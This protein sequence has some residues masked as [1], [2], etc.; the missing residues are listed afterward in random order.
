MYHHYIDENNLPGRLIYNA[1]EI[2][3]EVSCGLA[4][5]AEDKITIPKSLYMEVPHS[6]AIYARE[7]ILDATTITNVKS[8][9]IAAE[10][11][12]NKKLFMTSSDN[13]LMNGVGNQNVPMPKSYIHSSIFSVVEDNW[14]TNITAQAE[15]IEISGTLNAEHA[16]YNSRSFTLTES[17]IIQSVSITI[18]IAQDAHLNGALTTYEAIFSG[19]N[20]ILC[21]VFAINVLKVKSNGMTELCPDAQGSIGTI[22]VT[23]ASQFKQNS[24]VTI[25]NLLVIKADDVNLLTEALPEVIKAGSKFDN[26]NITAWQFAYSGNIYVANNGTLAL[27][28]IRD[29]FRVHDELL[30][31]HIGLS[32]KND[33]VNEGSI[34]ANT[35]TL[36]SEFGSFQTKQSSIIQVTE[37]VHLSIWGNIFNAGSIKAGAATF[38]SSSG[39]FKAEAQS[40]IHVLGHMKLKATNNVINYGFIKASTA[41]FYLRSQFKAGKNSRLYVDG[42]SEFRFSGSGASLEMDESDMKLGAVKVLEAEDIECKGCRF[43]VRGIEA[44]NI[45]TVRFIVTREFRTK[46]D[47][48]SCGEHSHQW[49]CV[50]C[51]GHRL[52]SGPCEH[53]YHNYHVSCTQKT[54]A[55]NKAGVFS[56]NG[57]LHLSPCDI[58]VYASDV[59]I[60]TLHF[61]YPDLNDV[62]TIETGR[63]VIRTLT[64]TGHLDQ[65][66]DYHSVAAE[67]GIQD[68]NIVGNTISGVSDLLPA[69]FLFNT[70]SVDIEKV[71]LDWSNEAQAVSE[72][73][74]ALVPFGF[75]ARTIDR[76]PANVDHLRVIFANHRAAEAEFLASLMSPK[77]VLP[78]YKILPLLM[79]MNFVSRCNDGTHQDQLDCEQY[80]FLKALGLEFPG[81]VPVQFDFETWSSLMDEF[82]YQKTDFQFIRIISAYGSSKSMFRDFALDA[83][84]QG[85]KVGAILGSPLSQA[86]KEK[87]EAPIVWPVWSHDC[88]ARNDFGKIQSANMR[89][90]S[91][92]LYVPSDYI[93]EKLSGAVFGGR[94]MNLKITNSIGI[95][96]NGQLLQLDT[97]VRGHVRQLSTGN[98]ALTINYENKQVNIDTEGAI[99]TI[100]VE[101]GDVINFGNIGGKF[102]MD[103]KAGKY[104]SIGGALNAVDQGVLIAQKGIAEYPLRSSDGRIVATAKNTLACGGD[105]CVLYRQSAGDI[106]RFG[107]QGVIQGDSV[108]LSG[109]NIMWQT[110][111]ENRKV[112]E[113]EGNTR[114]ARTA[115]KTFRAQEFATGQ[116]VMRADGKFIGRGIA[117]FAEQ[118]GVIAGR[119]GTDLR[120]M[121]SLGEY[122]SKT[123]K[124]HT[125]SKHSATVEALVTHTSLVEV[126]TGSP[127]TPLTIGD[128]DS[129]T[130][131][132]GLVML[133]GET[134]PGLI[135][136]GGKGSALLEHL[137]PSSMRVTMKRSG[138]I[139]GHI[140]K[141]AMKNA[142]LLRNIE[143]L[144]YNDWLGF[145]TGVI[146][147]AVSSYR[148]FGTVKT[149]LEK[150]QFIKDLSIASGVA[151]LT[152]L[153][154]Q[155]VRAGVSFGR[156]ITVISSEGVSSVPN[157]IGKDRSFGDSESGVLGIYINSDY[158]MEHM[159][160]N[161]QKIDKVIL[162]QL[163]LKPGTNRL[164]RTVNHQSDALS[165]DI[166]L[167]GLSLMTGTAEMNQEDEQLMPQQSSF[168]GQEVIVVVN[169]RLEIEGTI[170][171]GQQV[172]VEMPE[173]LAKNVLEKIRTKT[174]SVSF[175]VGVAIGWDGQVRPAFNIGVEKGL[176]DSSLAKFVSGITGERVEIVANRIV[177]NLD[178]ITARGELLMKGTRIDNSNNPKPTGVS[179]KTWS[180][181]ASLGQN[182]DGSLNPSLFASHARDGVRTSVH[183]SLDLFTGLKVISKYLDKAFKALQNSVA[184]E[185][186]NSHDTK[187]AE[188]ESKKFGKKYQ[189]RQ[190]R[191]KVREQR[192]AEA[193]EGLKDTRAEIQ[194][195]YEAL[196]PNKK[197]IFDE[198]QKFNEAILHR[199]R[200][201]TAFSRSDLGGGN[202]DQLEAIITI[203]ESARELEAKHLE[204]KQKHPE[205]AE[206]SEHALNLN[207]HTLASYAPEFFDS[208]A[209]KLTSLGITPDS[210]EA[211]LR[212]ALNKLENYL[213]EHDAAV[214]TN[215]GSEISREDSNT[216]A[217]TAVFEYVIY[218]IDKE[219]DKSGNPTSL[220]QVGHY[221]YGVRK[222]GVDVVATTSDGNPI[223]DKND[224]PQ[225]LLL[226]KRQ[227]EGFRFKSLFGEVPSQIDNIYRI[228]EIHN[229]ARETDNQPKS[230]FKEYPIPIVSEE[231]YNH[232][233]AFMTES[234]DKGSDGTYSA[235]KRH[236]IEIG[237]RLHQ[238]A[239]LQGDPGD[240]IARQDFQ[241][242]NIATSVF[243]KQGFAGEVVY[244]ISKLPKEEF[245]QANNLSP[246]LVVDLGEIEMNN[247]LLDTF[248]KP[249]LP[250]FMYKI[251]PADSN[252][253]KQ[254]CMIQKS[255]TK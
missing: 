100:S 167:S 132:E 153:F 208:L 116:L 241:F 45:E 184:F 55:H 25:G 133:G 204:F 137:I 54:Y 211:D 146:T 234:L 18:N 209:A 238:I 15:D 101:Q 159:K 114:I 33:I 35:A 212:A 115:F 206:L 77:I 151:V 10:P 124:Y 136:R 99:A 135:I 176:K 202:A 40:Q 24:N 23:S 1:G 83:L 129:P 220:F 247:L 192:M 122:F 56:I 44:S 248:V 108:I 171:D 235:S 140:P 92:E 11:P 41:V 38:H 47:I 42:M 169:D 199:A 119:A 19:R 145:T 240:Y 87:L 214:Y 229:N 37:D 95:G 243:A 158:R 8:V 198:F 232:V 152:A 226:S 180:V 230:G 193:E 205:L 228:N 78:E 218:Q 190:E 60:K 17:G 219:V 161:L 187:T 105:D 127:D 252:T 96:P 31:G 67:Y 104:E 98:G 74:N 181:Q 156:E 194:E 154:G 216:L 4:W 117:A 178:Q 237:R 109:G 244:R 125:L 141:F 191:V 179:H 51:G 84:T 203:A 196:E 118:G 86:Q 50:C 9:Y 215:I 164:T 251:L 90:I 130:V 250:T 7:V 242:G 106:K 57:V 107:T 65:S 165:F 182:I 223:M 131:I 227:Q 254:C 46:A 26:C 81:T 20:L 253:E 14:V 73:H 32:I 166:S 246:N 221:Y 163:T 149:T 71:L 183:L 88:L 217:S 48:T 61:D 128:S 22:V 173:V 103:V 148:T 36:Q 121:T 53:T 233:K 134:G 69:R 102:V 210:S 34:K 21:G 213:L 142:N 207:M 174:D 89:C 186:G 197:K 144:G 162:G 239:G 5:H 85:K 224:N 6:L 3:D 249:I 75:F 231:S 80:E 39:I 94:K 150:S 64:I 58:T 111:H 195:E 225:L 200:E 201:N 236:C 168:F 76:E 177:A 66:K 170:I 157:Q 143:S 97:E 63:Q 68:G 30:A 120:A 139:K 91:Y 172:E 43:I 70:A 110:L 188:P 160:V 12:R 72:S 62:L 126:E 59:W 123:V 112:H 185:P 28:I 155:C 49:R 82:I 147:D 138:L 93:M 113:F 13:V 29:D 189:A 16:K 27:S 222:N 79:P 52:F 2:E 255:T 175:G 245:T